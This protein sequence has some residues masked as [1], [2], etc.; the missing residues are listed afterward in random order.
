MADLQTLSIR[1]DRGILS[2]LQT[3]DCFTDY[4]QDVEANWQ[5]YRESEL[6]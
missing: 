2:T 6:R 3:A 5:G 4:Y 1:V